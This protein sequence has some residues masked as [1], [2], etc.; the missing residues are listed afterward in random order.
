MALAVGFLSMGL[1]ECSHGMAADFS[2]ERMS[3]EANVEAAKPFMI[4]L[5]SHRSISHMGPVL[6]QGGRDYIRLCVLGNW[7][8]GRHLRRWSQMTGQ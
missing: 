1:L 2:P 4:S 8:P 3:Q 5:K 7:A 6:L